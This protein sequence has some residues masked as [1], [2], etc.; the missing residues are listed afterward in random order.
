MYSW[1]RRFTFPYFTHIQ[2]KSMESLK[3]QSQRYLLGGLINAPTHKLAK[4]SAAAHGVQT[5]LTI[6]FTF[7]KAR[8]VKHV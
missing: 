4:S 1:A 6:N 7:Q 8:R 5:V 3:S 2:F